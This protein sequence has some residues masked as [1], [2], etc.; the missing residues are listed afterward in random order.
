MK[1]KLHGWGWL[2]NH[3]YGTDV[4]RLKDKGFGSVS[5]LRYRYTMAGDV[6]NNDKKIIGFNRGQNVRVL[7]YSK[8]LALALDLEK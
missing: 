3:S 1:A 5:I 7:G 8:E 6:E 4:S 2:L